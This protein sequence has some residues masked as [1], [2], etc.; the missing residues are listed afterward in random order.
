MSLAR[1]FS[2]LQGARQIATCIQNIVS[3]LTDVANMTT[4]NSI[5]QQVSFHVHLISFKPWYNIGLCDKA[6][7]VSHFRLIRFERH[8]QTCQRKMLQ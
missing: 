3:T 6:A 7:L 1:L 4:L 5:F 8:I 2:S